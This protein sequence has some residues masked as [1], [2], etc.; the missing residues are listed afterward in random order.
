MKVKAFKGSSFMTEEVIAP[1]CVTTS[2]GKRASTGWDPGAAF[3]FLAS[4]EIVAWGGKLIFEKGAEKE[5]GLSKYAYMISV[6]DCLCPHSCWIEEGSLVLAMVAGH[7]PVCLLP[8]RCKPASTSGI[9]IPRSQHGVNVSSVIMYRL[10]CFGDIAPSVGMHCTYAGRNS[11]SVLD[12]PITCVTRL[13]LDEWVDLNVEERKSCMF[14]KFQRSQQALPVRKRVLFKYQ[15]VISWGFRKLSSY[16]RQ[17]AQEV[18]HAAVAAVTEVRCGSNGMLNGEDWQKEKAETMRSSSSLIMASYSGRDSDTEEPSC[19][20]HAVRA[21]RM[22]TDSGE[23]K[24]YVLSSFTAPKSSPTADG[25]SF[26]QALVVASPH[27]THSLTFCV[28]GRL[29]LGSEKDTRGV[30]QTQRSCCQVVYQEHGVRIVREGCLQL[31]LQLHKVPSC[32]KQQEAIYIP[33]SREELR[34]N[35][36][37]PK[38]LVAQLS[39]FKQAELQKGAITSADQKTTAALRNLLF[40]APQ[41][42]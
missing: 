42:Q 15:T 19:I 41:F 8:H 9:S 27:H 40:P 34:M 6:E 16:L 35:S 28:L 17:F 23:E 10:N 31:T 30:G 7:E 12:A 11:S 37:Q 2:H 14:G 29:G 20:R 26:H 13:P 21:L 18:Y 25:L 22:E 5:K 33:S 24:V 3:S 39:E 1:P 38:F 32:C 36:E 4:S